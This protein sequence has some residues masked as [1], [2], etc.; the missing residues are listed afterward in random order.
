[1]AVSRYYSSVARRTTLTAD[2]NA[3]TTSLSVAAATGFPSLYP[4]TLI[5][6]Q[7][8][9]NEEIVTVTNRS[10]TTLTVVRGSDGT[11]GTAHTAGA[12]V[13]HGVSARDFSESRQHE[14]ATEAVH[15]LG[16]G[17]AVVG[18][19]DAQTL[20][21]KTL[22]APTVAGGT[23]SGTVTN[24]GT[25]SGGTVNATTL[26]QGGVQAVTTTGTQTVSNKTLGSNLAAGGFKITGLADP[27]ASG[28]AATKN[29]TDTG[30]TSQVVAAAASASAAAGSASAASGSASAAS[31][32]ASAASS[33][34][35][36]SEVSRLA[37][38]SARDAAV[39]AKDAAEL[40]ETNAET[41]ETAAELAETNAAAS[42]GLANEWATK[43]SGAVAGGEFSAKYHAQAAAASADLAGDEADASAASALAAS[44]SASAAAAS[45]AS[46]ATALDNFDDRYLGAKASDPTLDNDGN[47]LL[48]GALYFNTA[49]NKMKVY[50]GS[51]WIV[52]SEAGTFIDVSLLDAKGDLIAASAADTPARLA[53]GTN[54]YVLT[55]DSAE[56]TG[57]KWALAAA[58]ATG[59]GTNQIFYENEQ[60]VTDNYTISTNKNAGTFGPVTIDSGV[61]VT[62]PSGSVWSV[63]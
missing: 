51:V 41:A 19:T 55:A 56:A 17:S 58:G 10:G 27:T 12:S 23:L 2:A 35:S 52:T 14:D 48:T 7:D 49:V 30:M 46:A 47:A 3:S 39:I 42:A 29:Y 34:A 36:A 33:S 6:D 16:A 1:M 26:Q 5:L 40:A 11:S 28:D 54:G 8:T 13:E 4:Y 18:T 59:G 43:T 50:D 9:V 32:S 53:V 15:G 57:L 62:I 60:T 61:T 31:G 63:V 38:E 20:T 44:G 21:N 45:A 22:T 24:S 37:S 25:V